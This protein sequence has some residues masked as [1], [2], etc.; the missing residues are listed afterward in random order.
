MNATVHMNGIRWEIKSGYRITEQR[1][2]CHQHIPSFLADVI[3]CF[4]AVNSHKIKWAVDKS[5]SVGE[6][7]P[8]ANRKQM[9]KCGT[10]L[11]RIRWIYQVGIKV[12]V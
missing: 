3:P 11:R 5:V 7:D 12:A 8:A 4:T 9:V 6:I 1:G 10:I 2:L